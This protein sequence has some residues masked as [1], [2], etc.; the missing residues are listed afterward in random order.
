[1][2]RTPL[3]VIVALS[4]VLVALWDAGALSTRVGERPRTIWRAR[5]S[6]S[7]VDV[8][9]SE[10]TVTVAV[11]TS[12]PS[13]TPRAV[14]TATPAATVTPTN[15][16][17][18]ST[19]PSTTPTIPTPGPPKIPE[20]G[21]FVLVDQDEQAMRVYE[22]GVEVR[23][24]PCS[25][26]LP[27]EKTNTPAWEGV[28]GEYWGT[29][30]AYNVYADEAWYLFKSLGSILIHSSPYTVENGV[31]VYQE[32]EALGLR[33]ASHGCIRIA[34]EDAQWFTEW[35]PEGVPIVITPL[36]EHQGDDGPD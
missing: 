5:A 14:R 2:R 33:P 10:P 9:T 12:D 20:A 6:E 18:A 4:L 7:R 28:V 32:L 23:T 15:E 25:S 8:P 36:V 19:T 31:K 24:M 11:P 35:E 34:P 16:L 3:L 21:R 30:F 27:G 29:F 26:G 17:R 13:P 22:D 1:M